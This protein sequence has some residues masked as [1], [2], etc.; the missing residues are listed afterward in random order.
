MKTYKEIMERSVIECKNEL[1]SGLALCTED[2]QL[3]FR[4]M[5]SGRLLETPI[6]KLVDHMPV[7]K[8]DWAMKQVQ[9][10]IDKNKK[11]EWPELE[12]STIPMTPREIAYR[13]LRLPIYTQDKILKKLK[14]LQDDVFQ[15]KDIKPIE[16]A[17]LAF[18]EIRKRGII[19]ELYQA[20]EAEYSED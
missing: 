2:Q 19:K 14:A 18:S 13:F 15:D 9:R 12:D 16:R 11:E 1:K 6:G 20:I 17:R 10:T 3:L 4:K 7:E 5:Y 8:L